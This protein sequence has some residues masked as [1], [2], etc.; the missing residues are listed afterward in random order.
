VFFLKAVLVDRQVLLH[1]FAEHHRVKATGNPLA[2]I[3][4][5]LTTS[6]G[7]SSYFPTS[8]LAFRSLWGL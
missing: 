7:I 3:I 5:P 2:P 6:E 1:P 8:I 4:V